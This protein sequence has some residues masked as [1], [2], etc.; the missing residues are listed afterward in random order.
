[1]GAFDFHTRA[2]GATPEEAFNAAVD[3]AR[4]EH[5]HG[6]YTGTIAEKA[7]DGFVMK[8]P[9]PGETVEQLV[10]RTLDDNEKWGPAFCVLL[11]EG[12]RDVGERQE[13]PVVRERLQRHPHAGTRRW[14]TVYVLYQDEEVLP[15][16]SHPLGPPRELERSGEIGGSALTRALETVP[17]RTIKT[18]VA[19]APDMATAE[20]R[21]RE[22]ARRTRKPVTVELEKR[23]V[24]SSPVVRTVTPEVPA[25]KV[26]T[27]RVPHH[28]YLFYGIAS[29]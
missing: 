15:L 18:A 8:R 4:H 20:R 16:P 21:A 29:S 9:R 22:L 7:G 13:Q 25:P 27:R 14:E 1:M 6:G 24:G 5:G 28:T 10:E 12:F 26:T 11:E 2:Q 17:A 3:Q 19:T 23:L